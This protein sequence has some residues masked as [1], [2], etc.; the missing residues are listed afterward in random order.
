MLI[1][2]AKVDIPNMVISGRGRPRLPDIE[3]FC[4]KAAANQRNAGL[5]G[6]EE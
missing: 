6:L 5:K 2:S 4:L 3:A 1:M